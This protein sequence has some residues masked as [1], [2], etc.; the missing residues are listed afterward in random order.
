[1]KAKSD[2]LSSLLRS[3]Y[4][5]TENGSQFFVDKKFLFPGDAF[6]NESFAN[7]KLVIPTRHEKGEKIAH[8]VENAIISDVENQD[9]EEKEKMMKLAT[10]LTEEEAEPW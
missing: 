6:F 3:V 10:Q 5:K 1:V 8:K 7:K 4:V 9:E 2:S